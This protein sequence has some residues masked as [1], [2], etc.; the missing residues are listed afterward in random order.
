M[1]IALNLITGHEDGGYP[2]EAH[3]KEASKNLQKEYPYLGEWR[4]FKVKE[5]YFSISRNKE[6]HANNTE[7]LTEMNKLRSFCPIENIEIHQPTNKLTMVP[8]IKSAAELAEEK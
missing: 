5:G 6:F 7:L 4:V 1:Y 3:A 2:N 8:P